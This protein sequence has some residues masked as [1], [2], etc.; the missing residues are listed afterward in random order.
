MDSSWAGRCKGCNKDSTDSHQALASQMTD[1]KGLTAYYKTEGISVLVKSR[2]LNRSG[3]P[4]ALARAYEK[5]S[6]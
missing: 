6:P 4:V 5:Q 1:A 2:P 3:R